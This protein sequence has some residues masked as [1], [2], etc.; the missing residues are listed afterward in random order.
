MTRMLFG[1][2]PYLQRADAMVV[3]HTYEGGIGVE[4]TVFTP[5]AAASAATAGI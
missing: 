1:K 3:T 4:C 5:R 2:D